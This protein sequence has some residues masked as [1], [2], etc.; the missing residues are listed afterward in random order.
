M[1]SISISAREA[2]DYEQYKR[3]K[4]DLELRGKL[5]KLEPSL[6]RKGATAIEI[7]S[8]CDCVRR[9]RPASVCVQPIY[10]KACKTLLK[11]CGVKLSCVVGINSESGTE[12]KLYEC[13]KLLRSGV[14][15]ID[16]V[17]CFTNL[18]NG[19]YA[20]FQRELKRVLR[21]MRGKTV[22]LYLDCAGLREEKL[23]RAAQTAADAGIKVVSLTADDRLIGEMQMALRGRCFVM[24]RGV[25]DA[26]GFRKMLV[27]NCVKIST[28]RTE[29]IVAAMEEEYRNIAVLESVPRLPVAEML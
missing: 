5:Q 4:L 2:A 3:R 6:S 23:F 28:E 26:D 10:L 17:P 24:A 19:N 14:G 8:F 15:E 21:V 29:E 11:G 16:Y 12:V 1:E 7:R 13:K 22:K 20:A 25:Q 9:F 27:Q 18:I